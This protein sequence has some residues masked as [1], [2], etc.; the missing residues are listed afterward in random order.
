M[1]LSR[2]ELTIAPGAELTTFQRLESDKW[3]SAQALSLDLTSDLRVDHLAPPT[4]SDAA[5]VSELVAAHDPGEGRTTV[6]ALNGDFFDINASSAPLG[7]GVAGGE[8]VHS[9]TGSATQAVGIGPSS[10]GRILDLYFEGTLTLPGGEAE[11]DSF[12]AADVPLGGIGLYTPAW[13]EADRALTVEGAIDVT[14]VVVE[15]G[16]VTSVADKPGGEPVPDDAFVLLGREAGA[17]TLASLAAGDRVTTEYAPRTGDGGPL[18][19]TAV[20]GRG[21]LVVDGE[22]R[23]WEGLPNN[24]TAPRTAVGFSRDGQDMYVLTVDGRQAHSGGVTLTELA[25]M[26]TGLGAYNALNLDGGGST[27]LLARDP[28][29][30]APHVLNS[31]SDGQER[32]VPNGLAITAPVGSG[33]VTGYRVT[34]AADPATA[35]TA[36]TVPGGHPERVFPGLTRQ[37]TATAH[38]E[39]YGPAEGPAPRWRSSRTD[40]GRVGGDGVFRAGRPGTTEITAG[41]HGAEGSLELTVLGELDR[42]APT[43]LRVGLGDPGAEGTFGVIGRDAA[44]NSAP[45]EPA[46]A[47]LDYDTSLFTIEPDV[48][49]G[50][51][52]VTAASGAPSASGR[53]TVTVG[54]V[55]TVLAVTIGLEDTVTAD[56]ENAGEWTFSHA[57]AGGS[58]AP[59]PA[60]HRGG[61]LRLAYDFSR[62]TATR[63]AYVTPSADIPVAGQPQSFTMWINGDGRGAWPS[64]HLTDANGTSQVLRGDHITWEGWR[65]VT[66]DVPEGVAHPLSVR[67]F[68]IAETRPDQSYADEIVID[69][70]WAQTPPEVELPP[71]AGHRD[72]LIGTAAETAGRDWR[73]AVVSDAQFVARAP[74]SGIVAAARR[75]LRE[76]RAANPDF[77]VINGDWVDEGSPADL[78]FAREM[79]EEELGDDLPW[80]YVPGNH[81]VMG[82]SLDQF[83]AEFGPGQLT[84]DHRGT[85]FITLDTSSLTL[86]GGGY[87][88]IQELRAQ[89][90]D[91]A[92]D[93]SIG[94]VVV[95]GHVPPRD[96]TAQPASQLGDRREAALLEDWLADFRRETGKGVTYL[97]AHVGIFDSYHAEGVPYFI[98]GN[99]GKSPSAP[100]AR[101]GFGGWALVGVDEVS[102]AERARARHNPHQVLPDWVSVQTRPHVH[103]L[104]LGLPETLAAGETAPAGAFLTQDTPGGGSREVPLASPVSV[105]WSGS[106]ALHIGNPADAGRR[107]VAAL[108]PVTGEL[109]GLRPGEV[110]VKV[111]VSG[112]RQRVTVRV[113][114]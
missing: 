14:E 53:V 32:E 108:D 95:M 21:L 54:G 100:A 6:A 61:G 50:G 12:N 46:D 77:V 113:T 47:R 4:V 17:H 43:S 69:E 73:F 20:G 105:D 99:A 5:P 41:R 106:A 90:D 79:I 97:G 107:D 58:L 15:D 62:S 66:F 29:A 8:L 44:G 85:R 75:T 83:E 51:F 81:E 40:V 67:R 27:T 28:G 45:I 71:A 76:A 101:G 112:E 38:D 91:A 98:S 7:P 24:A 48:A 19:T 3:L 94:S 57:R 93:R 70:L 96:T 68:Y 22:P 35:P 33:E 26:M 23:N 80:Y 25:V 64:L 10:A 89:L 52:R 92:R 74:D 49:G 30:A 82:G 37:L 11:L 59:E 63:A 42:I 55:S 110:T 72:P 86:R 109:T 18:P 9:A 102:P 103:G 111:T 84:F 65:Q 39:T 1:E 34:T 13:G 31:P 60:G 36:D 114:R 56:F 87:E 88:Q 104:T 2:T 78:E 16:E